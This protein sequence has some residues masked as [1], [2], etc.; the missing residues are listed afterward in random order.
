M[1]LN[2]IL[3]ACASV[4]TIQRLST[5]KTLAKLF[6]SV[7]V[8]AGTTVD[9]PPY[10]NYKPKTKKVHRVVLTKEDLTAIAGKTNF[11]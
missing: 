3:E 1:T 10:L 11:P 5:S 2:I 7:W 8:T 4:R 9:P 6:V